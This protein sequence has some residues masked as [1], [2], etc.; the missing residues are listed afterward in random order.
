MIKQKIKD[1]KN[2]QKGY[3]LMVVLVITSLFVMVAGGLV[4]LALNQN[5]LGLKK[6]AWSR[7]F[8]IAEAGI[9]YYKWVLAHDPTDYYNGTGGDP[10]PYEID[11]TDPYGGVIGKYSLEITPPDS[12]SSVVV[13][14][15][16]GWT[17]DEP[18]VKRTLQARYGLPS[19]AEFAFLTNT[20]V[21][22]GEDEELKGPVHSNGGIRQD[23]END[24]LITSAKETY[25]CGPE[26]GCSNETKDGIW[27]DGEKKSLWKFPVAQVDFNSIISDLANLKS[28]A[29]S[30]STYYDSVGIG[31][32][33]VLQKNRTFDLY[34]V[35]NLKPPLYAYDGSK[36]VLISLDID[37]ETFIGNYS[38]PNNC[39]VLFFEDDVWVEGELD[40][41]SLTIVSAEL[42]E[43]ASTNTSIIING[44]IQFQDK[45]DTNSLALIAQNNIY[46]PFYSAPND[47]TVDAVLLA[48]NGKVFRHYYYSGSSYNIRDDI[49][50]YGSII[51][52]DVWTWTWV[53]GSGNV[54]SGYRNT[55]TLYDPNL[56]Y[57]PPPG[58]PKKVEYEFIK[59]EEI[60]DK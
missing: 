55:E 54:I 18:N 37:S 51:T 5:K 17:L 22:F 23:G 42:P 20:N 43:V 29:Q 9:N 45:T 33:V 46:I 12:C 57:Y 11:Y 8:Q 21:W 50:V 27:G 36:D 30:S 32:H 48:K 41:Y 56:K 53:N 35:D 28:Q 24:S 31:Y 49:E 3:L 34:K 1:K 4:S 6:I 25:T 44:N 38:L 19:L 13:I 47:L 59:W 16:T 10:G 2:N 15:S 26:H 39:S 58:F 52:N 14:K 7:S 60:T 40:G